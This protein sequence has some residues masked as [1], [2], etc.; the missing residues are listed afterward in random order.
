MGSKL[1][2]RTYTMSPCF[3]NPQFISGR[4]SAKPT[5]V[6]PDAERVCLRDGSMHSPGHDASPS[7]SFENA[8]GLEKGAPFGDQPGIRLEQKTHVA[9]IKCGS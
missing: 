2:L 3:Q 1:D 5:R 7:S 9:V 4:C 6:V 8:T